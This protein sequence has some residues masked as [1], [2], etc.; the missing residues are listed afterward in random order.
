MSARSSRPS[1]A[2]PKANT[3]ARTVR[4]R[5]DIYERLLIE[6]E[7]RDLSVAWLINRA[8]EELLERLVPVSVEVTPPAKRG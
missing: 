8:V 2:K 4:L 1:R 5:D 6:S 3:T 7:E